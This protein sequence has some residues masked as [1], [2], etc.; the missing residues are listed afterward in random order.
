MGWTNTGMGKAETETDGIHFSW[1]QFLKASISTLETSVIDF[2]EST[3]GLSIEPVCPCEETTAQWGRVDGSPLSLQE[4]ESMAFP[5]DSSPGLHQPHG[6]G[7]N[8]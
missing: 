7:L 5:E 8:T 4:H 6:G 3:T 1:T 2:G